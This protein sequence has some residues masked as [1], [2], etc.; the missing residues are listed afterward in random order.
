MYRKL[1]GSQ[2]RVA[3]L[4]MYVLGIASLLCGQCERVNKASFAGITLSIGANVTTGVL[5]QPLMLHLS[6]SNTSAI[7]FTLMD[8][9]VERDFELHVTD[10]RGIEVPLTEFGAKI[11]ASPYR[12]TTLHFV[13]VAPGETVNGDED[14]TRIYSLT[15]PGIYSV[16]A[17]RIVKNIGAVYSNKVDILIKNPQKPPQESN[18]R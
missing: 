2:T 16:Q 14:V 13:S 18:A 8:R 12:D 5:G 15:K 6:V 3:L 4:P 1:I 17:C 7:T 11:R 9:F 10:S